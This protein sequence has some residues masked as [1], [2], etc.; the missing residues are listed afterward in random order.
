MT[1]SNKTFSIKNGLDVANTIV[2]DSSRN[3]SNVASI[4]VAGID[5]FSISNV[6]ANSVQVSQ[7][8]GGTLY[9]KSL[10]FVNTSS[11]TVSVSAN[12]ANANI[13]FSSTVGGPQGPQGAQGPSGPSGP[14]SSLAASN[15]VFRGVKGGTNQT[16]NN[17]SDAIVTF[18]DDY[19]PQGWLTSNQFKPNVA[20]YYQINLQIWWQPG[21]IN[22]NQSNIQLRKNG[23]TQIAIAQQPISN[24]TIGYAQAI[25]T[26]I[27]LNGS[28]DY[29]EVTAYTAN[30]TSQIIDGASSGTWFDAHLI[31]YGQTGP[32][33]PQGPQG[34]SGPQGPQGSTGSQ[35]PQG[36][37]GPSGAQGST[38]STG[39]QGPQGPQGPSGAQ[40]TAGSTG[41]QGPQ[42][43]Q[44]PSGAQ[45]STGSTG[46]TGSQ[47]PQGPSGPEGP[48]GAQGTAGP[49]GPQ[50]PSGVDGA[51]GPQGPQG[52]QGSTGATGSQGPQGPQGPSGP[53]GP[54][55]AQGTAGSRGPQGPQGP[56][57]AQGPQGPQGAQ[58]VK[59]DTG[60]FG[61][62]SFDYYYLIDTTDID[63]GSGNL[64]FNAAPFNT[65]TELYIDFNDKNAANV[66]NYLD[67]I[68]D[69]TSSIKGT[70]KVS[71]TANTLEYAD[72]S[73]TGSHY[74]HASYFE[75]P[76][77]YLAGSVTSFANNTQV[78]ITFVRTGDKGDTG[79][80]GP[81]GP[82]GAQ[83]PSGPTP[84]TTTYSANSI[85]LTGGSYVSG[86]LTDIQTF[87]DGNSYIFTDGSGVTPAWNVDID[88]TSVTSFTQVDL[89]IQ[90]TQ[91]SGHTVYVRLYN[92]DTSQW[93]SLGSYNGLAGYY[94][95]QLGI[96]SSDPYINSGRVQLRLN[97]SNA[98]NTSHQTNIDYAAVVDAISGA[99]GPKGPQGPSGAQGPSGPS[100]P[101]GAS[102]TGPSG[103]SGPSGAGGG[104]SGYVIVTANGASSVNSSNINFVNTASVTVSVTSDPNGNANIAFTST[105]GGSGSG[106]AN[107]TISGSA[108]G[109]ATANNDL[110]WDTE[111]GVLK[112]Y[113][114]DGNSSQWVDA[115]VSNAG[116]QGPSGAQGPQGPSGPGATLTILNPFLL[117]GM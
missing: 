52:A 72:F 98:G 78:V 115:V 18:V 31:A 55:G 47:G 11:V 88:F 95:F 25:D 114:N 74:H 58:G 91:A 89:N 71:N 19:D 68:D 99:A 24:T 12:G 76:V 49:R 7:N 103:P 108:P 20:G 59:G 65:A 79:P 81:Q 111:S 94:Q 53:E 23:S 2:L 61:G 22:N 36:P 27:Y 101:S 107:L 40:G 105:G 90:Y 117:A 60:S 96:I 14:A 100:G 82:Q 104:G 109:S 1:T 64:A 35:G 9:N 6:A 67:T 57:G 30:P 93:D 70:F 3:L 50:G 10:N 16:I 112:V 80:Q 113:Y 39:S 62:A 26:T 38:G 85:A 87:G 56:S 42:G 92:N 28:T 5:V 41:S 73:I 32:Q 69:S 86:G 8:G 63:P 17:G 54:Q 77:A 29:V 116:P 21:S 43:P 106:N 45:G 83:G 13:A 84:E 75:V 51:E 15:Y 33:G 48:Q 37:Q 46:S 44:G 4:N 102:V 66:S 34:P 97:H 110:W